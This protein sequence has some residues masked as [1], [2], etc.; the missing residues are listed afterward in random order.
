MGF[1][2][3][4]AADDPRRFAVIRSSSGQIEV[5]PGL[6]EIFQ[7]HTALR[8]ERDTSRHDRRQGL[9]DS[10]PVPLQ[11]MVVNLASVGTYRA[12]LRCGVTAPATPAQALVCSVS[13]EIARFFSFAASSPRKR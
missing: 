6:G 3:Q 8:L 13:N 12:K 10:L 2:W 1:D 11:S 9:Y 7:L 4:K 5:I